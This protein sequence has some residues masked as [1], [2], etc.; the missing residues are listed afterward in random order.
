MDI[1]EI[2]IKKSMGYMPNLGRIKPKIPIKKKL[3]IAT[4]LIAISSIPGFYDQKCLLSLTI[5]IVNMPI[6]IS[7]I[8]VKL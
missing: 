3:I 7:N 8:V 5:N 6:N 4:M 2:P 1:K